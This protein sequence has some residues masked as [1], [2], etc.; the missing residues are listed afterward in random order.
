MP[1]DLPSITQRIPEAFITRPTQNS[2]V[3]ETPGKTP[4]KLATPTSETPSYD[5]TIYQDVNGWL[6]PKES[7]PTE[8]TA[9]KEWDGG[10]TLN[11]ETEV[12]KPVEVIRN[13]NTVEVVR[14]RLN[15]ITTRDGRSGETSRDPY[16]Y[17]R[18]YYDLTTG[19][20]RTQNYGTKQNITQTV[21]EKAARNEANNTRQNTK[22]KLS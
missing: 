10:K 11:K 20:I 19:E 5:T 3:G 6:V 21:A 15:E 17:Q 13:G 22:Q 14:Y 12:Y 8:Y 4:N 18:Q 7:A 2:R 16:V 9:R 1:G